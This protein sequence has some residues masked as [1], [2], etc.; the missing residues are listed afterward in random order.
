MA[1][2]CRFMTVRTEVARSRMAAFLIGARRI[3]AAAS[4][5]LAR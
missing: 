5:V 2:E 4:Q 3:A 1:Q